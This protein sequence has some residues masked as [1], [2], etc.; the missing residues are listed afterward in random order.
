MMA[1]DAP[2]QSGRPDATQADLPDLPAGWTVTT[3][4]PEHIAFFNTGG[5]P[6]ETDTGYRRSI[7]LTKT[8]NAAPDRWTVSGLAGYA[9]PPLLVEGVPFEEALAAAIEEMEAVNSGDPTE[10]EPEA[11]ASDDTDTAA[12]EQTQAAA[13]S[14]APQEAGADDQDEETPEQT[15][16]IDE[17]GAE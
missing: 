11:R 15:S 14:T 1:E 2:V 9:P 8:P 7:G 3:Q 13:G 5:D 12:R 16:L 10:G 4:V 6:E 17:W